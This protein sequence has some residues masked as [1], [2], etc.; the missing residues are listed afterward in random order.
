MSRLKRKKESKKKEQKISE[1]RDI[2]KE[3][4]PE[5]TAN[6]ISNQMMMTLR[7]SKGYRWSHKDKMI[8]LSIYYCSQKAYAILKKLFNLPSKSTLQRTLSKLNVQPG[9]SSSVINILKMKVAT[10]SPQD[11][12]CAL[13]FDEMTIKEALK[14]CPH[15]DKM[16]GF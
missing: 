2:L 9:I 16:S 3:F 13:V 5:T 8:A 1:A 7:Q 4:F 11:R 15:T 10:M 12:V 14:Y 6:F